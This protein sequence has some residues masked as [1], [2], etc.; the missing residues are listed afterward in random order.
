M[1]HRLPALLVDFLNDQASAMDTVSQQTYALILVGLLLSWTGNRYFY[2]CKFCSLVLLCM[3][4][5]L[6]PFVILRL[7]C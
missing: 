3:F 2:P 7:L 1:Y 4:K 6:T 5:F